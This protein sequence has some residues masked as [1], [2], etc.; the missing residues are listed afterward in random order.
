[1]DHVH[2]LAQIQA[3]ALA[4]RHNPAGAGS[5]QPAERGG[6]GCAFFH[7]HAGGVA[8]GAGVKEGQLINADQS[9]AA[10]V[11]ADAQGAQ[12]MDVGQI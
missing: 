2:L 3:R 9:A 7:E 1:M 6:E 4:A 12:H 5:H 10:G 8:L 11:Q